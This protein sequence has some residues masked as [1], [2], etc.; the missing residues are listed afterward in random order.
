[1]KYLLTGASG[2]LGRHI[3]EVLTK[4]SVIT[5][6]RT[7]NNV[8]ITD[9]SKSIPTLLP[10]DV[11]IHCAGKAHTV[12]KTSEEANDFYQVNLIGTQNLL[13]A[14]DRL[15]KKPKQLIF[16]SSVSVY[17][18]NSGQMISETH[19]LLG[20]SPYAESKILAEN[21][22]LDW[23]FDHQVPAIILRLPLLI[24]SDPPGNLGKMI[25]GIKNKRYASINGGKA[26]KSMVLASDVARLIAR[27]ENKSGIYNLTDR[28]HPSFNQ[29]E[30]QLCEILNTRIF[31][32]LP[33]N[34]A[35]LLAGMGDEF[36]FFPINSG[37]IDKI[38]LDLT[39]DDS[40]AVKDLNWNPDSV[41]QKL[42]E[43]QI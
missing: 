13:K 39:F 10:A 41:L 5:V 4:N 12:P 7:S 40:A 43:L 1:M 31:L 2:F 22:V 17:G 34:L 37:L 23:S 24:G 32:K 19:P 28:W 21:A 15:D 8:V 38:T 11:V 26:R 35:K 25:R 3:L 27:L 30:K 29:L 14:L 20:N 33:L 6:G 18:L 42:H 9:L 36:S 16:I